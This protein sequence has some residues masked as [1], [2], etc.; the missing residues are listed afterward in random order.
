MEKKKKKSREDQSNSRCADAARFESDSREDPKWLGPHSP[1]CLFKC[2]THNIHL[3]CTFRTPPDAYSVHGAIKHTSDYASQRLLRRGIT[4]MTIVQLLECCVRSSSFTTSTCN[5]PTDAFK[6]QV[7]DTVPFSFCL[8]D[9]RVAHHHTRYV[10]TPKNKYRVLSLETSSPSA[11][12][13]TRGSWTVS[14][15]SWCWSQTLQHWLFHLICPDRSHVVCWSHCVHRE[16]VNVLYPQI[17]HGCSSH[18]VS[19]ICVF[20]KLIYL[21]IQSSNVTFDHPSSCCMTQLYWLLIIQSRKTIILHSSNAITHC[22]IFAST[23]QTWPLIL[24]LTF[25]PSCHQDDPSLFQIDV[26]CRVVMLDVHRLAIVQDYPQ[27]LDLASYTDSLHSEW[28]MYP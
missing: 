16:R 7:V 27:Q 20:A 24:T 15:V 6:L 13:L 8:Y 14:A 1:S 9:L 12:A 28:S 11:V 2:T 4:F 18:T 26:S 5:L 19:C 21:R 17:C 25:C 3:D 10:R 23:T 22:L